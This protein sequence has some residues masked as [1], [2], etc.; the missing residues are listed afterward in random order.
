[1]FPL[2][3]LTLTQVLV[4]GKMRAAAGEEMDSAAGSVPVLAQAVP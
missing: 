1:M 3:S 2:V 4:I